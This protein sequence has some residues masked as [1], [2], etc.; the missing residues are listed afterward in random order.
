MGKWCVT[1][2]LTHLTGE[3][4]YCG[5]RGEILPVV[6]MDLSGAGVLGY[7]E[8]FGED[9]NSRHI[10]PANISKN[11]LDLLNDFVYTPNSHFKIQGISRFGFLL[12]KATI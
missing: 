4:G 10:I 6:E 5:V 9:A 3:C 7:E 11:I 8:K 1:L 12:K 2:L